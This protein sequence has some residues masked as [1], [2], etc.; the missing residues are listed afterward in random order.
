V[1]ARVGD[2]EA[3][4]GFAA[5]AALSYIAAGSLDCALVIGLA[6]DRGYAMMLVT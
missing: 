5:A 3:V 1:A 2:H 6:R 4:G